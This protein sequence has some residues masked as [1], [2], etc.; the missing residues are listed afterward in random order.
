[1]VAGWD[2]ILSWFEG[3]SSF[4]DA[5]I[6]ELH[7]DR[8]GDSYIRVHWWIM[9]PELDERGYY[10]LDKH[11]IVTFHLRGISDLDLNGFNSQNV[12]FGLEIRTSDEGLKLLLEPCHG[13]SGT[14]TAKEISA[15]IASGQPSSNS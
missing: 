12:I 5:E 1:M 3:K 10:L 14:I 4:H 7:L 11:A 9:R 15:E 13:L 8:A 2:N 6:V